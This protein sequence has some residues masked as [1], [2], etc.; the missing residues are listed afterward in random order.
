[1]SLNLWLQ[2]EESRI[3]GT[4][5]FLLALQGLPGQYRVLI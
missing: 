1:M 2:S 3:E 4:V 5:G